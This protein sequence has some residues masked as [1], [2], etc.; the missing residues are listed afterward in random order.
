M[1]VKVHKALL[2]IK[3]YRITRK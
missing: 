2:F 1:D 3:Q